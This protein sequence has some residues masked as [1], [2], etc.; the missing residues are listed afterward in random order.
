M[1]LDAGERAVL[2]GGGDRAGVVDPSNHEVVVFRL[3]RVAVG[4]V[5]VRAVE[6]IE[7]ARRPGALELVPAHMR[8][9]AGVEPAYPTG[10]QA[11]AFAALLAL[12]EEELEPDADAEDRPAG[13]HALPQHVRKRHQ[14]RG[15][16]REVADPRH[17]HERRGGDLRRI[18]RDDRLLARAGER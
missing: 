13:P 17:D 6:A 5:D 16:A 12:P 4:E 1:E 14:P 15:G 10:E 8:H 7:D 9:R 2:D 18:N 3:D 11:Q